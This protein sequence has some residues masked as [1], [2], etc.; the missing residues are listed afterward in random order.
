MVMGKEPDNPIA[1]CVREE[2]RKAGL[3]QKE[4]ALHSGLGL[5]FIRNLEQG[6]T[7]LRTDKVNV[8]LAMFG[9]E[10]GPM[11]KAPHHE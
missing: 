6:K 1:V 8:A 10:L 7:S 2:R 5:N 9:F 11:K 4:F 3:T